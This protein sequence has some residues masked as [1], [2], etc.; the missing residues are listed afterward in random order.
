MDGIVL[1]VVGIPHVVTTGMEVTTIDG[2]D[3]GVI[4]RNALAPCSHPKMK[5]GIW[6]KISCESVNNGG[7]IDGHANDIAKHHAHDNGL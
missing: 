3:F 1:E 5:I 7:T 6:W 2:N 4:P